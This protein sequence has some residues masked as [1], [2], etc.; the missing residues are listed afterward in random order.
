MRVFPEAAEFVT[1]YPPMRRIM[2]H[3]ARMV[4]EVRP[5]ASKL[6]VTMHQ[7]FVFADMG[8][9]GDNSPEG[10]H[11][12]GADFIVSALVLERVG[13]LGG[14]SIV[15]GPDKKT[16]YLRQVLAPGEALFH[17][18]QGSELWHYVTPIKENPVEPPDYGHRSIIGFDIDMV[19]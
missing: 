6:E 1:D 2:M 15:Y 14:E 18:D 10:I 5:Q 12:D 9:T 3:L 16:E 17:A 19:G 11:Q 13:I 8:S 7:T 4:R